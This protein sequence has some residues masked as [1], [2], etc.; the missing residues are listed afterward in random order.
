MK[1][2]FILYARVAALISL[3]GF[4]LRI[5]LMFNEQTL[6]D[7]SFVE[8]LQIFSLGLINDIAIATLGFFFI[9]TNYLFVCK[10]K[11][12]SPL[13]YILF[14]LW[15]LA[16]FYV[17]AFNTI[18]DEYGSALPNIVRGLLLYKCTSFGIRLF[19]PSIRDKW[20]SIIHF[21][22]LAFTVFLVVENAC[23]EYLFWDEFG[24][25]YNF[26]AVDYLIYTN[27]VIGNIMESYPVFWI[28]GVFIALTVCI[29]YFISKGVSLPSNL[30]KTKRAAL[31][32]IYVLMLA[33]S[34]MVL[35]FLEAY[36]RTQNVYLSELS[37][38]GIFKFY[39][40]FFGSSLS[41]SKFYSLIDKNKALT[42]INSQY[43]SIDN[44]NSH[45]VKSYKKEIRANIIL[46]TVESLSA[47]FMAHFGSEKG[48]T[49]NLDSLVSRSIV[50]NNLYANGN[51]TVRGLEAYT[52][53]IPPSP[54]E[55]LIK[56]KKNANLFSVGKVLREKGYT[57]Q[58]IYG[59]DSYFDNMKKFFSGNGYDIIDKKSINKKDITFKNIWGVCDED[60]YSKTLKVMDANEAKG[61]PFFANI[62]T[63]S[64]HRP[65]TYPEG[66]IK[67]DNPK[68]RD[69]GVK[70]TDYAIGKFLRS[71]EKHSW[72]A[73]TVFIIAADH[74]AS[75]AGKTGVPAERYHIPVIIYAPKLIKPQ[76]VNTLASQIDVMPTV[77][78]LL[79]MSY[80]SEFYGCDVLNPTYHPRA[81]MATYQNL[82][83]LEDSVLTVLSPIRKVEQF[84][85]N[86]SEKYVYTQN[87]IEK[88]KEPYLNRAIANYQTLEYR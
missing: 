5:V 28:F 37:S 84:N 1:A 13:G 58:F 23:G 64:N 44:R 14:S 52:L 57:T 34:V 16:L 60:I 7:F 80:R 42:I 4:I 17:V 27:E 79:N 51:R 82:G 62:L 48:I 40:A 56:Q 41:Y 55:S 61:K 77:F 25:R 33:S 50:F 69:G 2:F 86:R 74:C 3:V 19:L 36:P 70:Y 39:K 65:Y 85:V 29:T 75:S 24:V 87:P 35:S 10:D 20:S 18:F 22:I 78:G 43:G 72:F 76:Q 66:K 30:K 54:G 47:E 53:C 12:R 32:G 73:N 11:Y 68:S 83:Y 46:I 71:A 26:I 6:S 67:I 45:E 9:G 8:T 63:V 49:P 88:A 15:C 59:G 81:F 21:L 38:N 31:S